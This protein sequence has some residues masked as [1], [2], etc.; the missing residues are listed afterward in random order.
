MLPLHYGVCVGWRETSRDD[1]Y[2]AL[3]FRAIRSR[4]Q[5]GNIQ[6]SLLLPIDPQV[7]RPSICV[8]NSLC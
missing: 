4:R 3:G 1:D 7:R 2:A 5:D 6:L 8:L